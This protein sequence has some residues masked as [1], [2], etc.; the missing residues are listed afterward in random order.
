DSTR[1]GRS[2]VPGGRE[3]TVRVIAASRCTIVSPQKKGFVADEESMA[4]PM[5]TWG[6]SLRHPIEEAD[7]F[8]DPTMLVQA[9]HVGTLDRL[10]RLPRSE[11]P[12]EA[13]P[14]PIAIGGA[15]EAEPVAGKLGSRRLDHCDEL[16][17]SVRRHHR[18]D[19]GSVGGPVAV[20]HR[21]APG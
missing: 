9:D 14:V 15:T 6:A 21:P 18:V 11:R 5:L 4:P 12:R 20:E 13:H 16:I 17:P 2:S 8:G 1:T 19:V 3:P 7:H 10:R